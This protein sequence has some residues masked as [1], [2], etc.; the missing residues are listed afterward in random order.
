M[1]KMMVNGMNSGHAKM[2]DWGLSHLPQIHPDEVV[3]LGCGGGRNVSELLKRFRSAR[4][5][6]IDYSDVSVAKATAYN[7]SEIDQGRC[8]ISQGDVSNLHIGKGRYDLATAFETV[9]FWPGLERCF[10]QVATGIKTG[11]YFLIVN[12]ANGIDEGTLK[13]EKIIDGMK[14]YTIEQL[15]EALLSSGFS[16]VTS[17]HHP[18]KPWI[19]VLAKK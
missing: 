2:A 1:G 10:S 11:G 3:D 18:D 13:Y 17:D 9:Y 7:R 5:L 6:G 4:V 12:E 15:E 16:Q 8:I 14:C 19:A